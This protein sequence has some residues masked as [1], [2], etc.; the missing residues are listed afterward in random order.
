MYTTYIIL[1][2]IP[3]PPTHS[4]SILY[5]L[6]TNMPTL[7]IMTQRHKWHRVHVWLCD[8]FH[9]HGCVPLPHSETLVV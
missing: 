7:T 3:T 1:Y 8:V 2:T 6:L 4:N 9:V 5:E